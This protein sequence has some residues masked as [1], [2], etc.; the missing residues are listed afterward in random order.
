M[1]KKKKLKGG[2]HAIPF[3]FLGDVSLAV[4]KF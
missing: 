4:P 2:H 3:I 1:I